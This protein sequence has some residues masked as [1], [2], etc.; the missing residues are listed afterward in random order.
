M[1]IN[2]SKQEIKAL[3]QF[4]ASVLEDKKARDIEIIDIGERSSLADYFVISSAGSNTQVKA[5]IGE[6]EEQVEEH[7][8]LKPNN[9]EGF[10]SRRWVLLDYGDIVV[11]VFLEEE[12]KYY[13]LDRLWKLEEA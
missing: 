10:Q 9:S 8:Q 3:A 13:D 7:H 11:H 12:R 4:I 2:K 6:V 1:K 5:L